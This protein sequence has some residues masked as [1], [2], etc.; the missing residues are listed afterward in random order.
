MSGYPEPATGKERDARGEMTPFRIIRCN[1]T[2]RGRRATRDAREKKT[3]V[4]RFFTRRRACVTDLARTR[5]DTDTIDTRTLVGGSEKNRRILRNRAPP[6]L[7]R[8]MWQCPSENVKGTPSRR[9]RWLARASAPLCPSRRG[10]EARRAVAAT[11]T[12]RWNLS[13][14]PTRGSARAAARWW[15]LPRPLTVACLGAR[16]P[17][18]PGPRTRRRRPPWRRTRRGP[19]PRPPRAPR[20]RRRS[21]RA[22][23][24]R[25]PRRR[26]A[27]RPSAWTNGPGRTRGP[28]KQ[29]RRPRPRQPRPRTRRSRETR[30][31]STARQRRAPCGSRATCT[32]R[33]GARD[34]T[35]MT[36]T[37]HPRKD[38]RNR[39]RTPDAVDTD[40]PTLCV[41]Y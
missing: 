41:K 1:K 27:V 28:R 40:A 12:P 13:R 19:G 39:A 23:R 30:R 14:D 31:R 22:L 7:F 10:L 6:P 26:R 35:Q 33:R 9:T 11:R 16:P 5:T 37:S 25:T 32:V 34:A 38:P 21:R 18:R 8:A 17:S 36:R 24:R 2:L 20:P 29:T 3:R 15:R 4:E